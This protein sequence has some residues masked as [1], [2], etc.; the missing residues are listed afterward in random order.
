MPGF[1]SKEKIVD[2]IRSSD[3]EVGKREIA[4]AFK[5][6]GQD[7]IQLKKVLRE[8]ADDGLI[9]KGRG[10]S[11]KDPTRLPPVTVIDIV[12][13]DT[14]GELLGRPAQWES[15]KRAPQIILAPGEGAGR[16]GGPAIG[17]GARV[18]A[19]LKK[20]PDE[21]YE[22]RVIKTLGQ[23]AHKVLGVVRKG[24]NPNEFR[25]KPVDRKTRYDILVDR[26]D[27]KNAAPG[28]LVTVEVK[29]GRKHAAKRGRVLEVLGDV[30]D[31]RSVSLI[32]IHTHGIPMGFSDDEETQ[33]KKAKPPALGRR[34]DLRHLPLITIDPD[35]ARDFDDAVCAEPDPSDD[36]VGGWI[37]HVA[38]ADVA[39]FV[40][41]GT[42]LDVGARKRGNSCYFPDRV[43][44]MLPE[45]LSNELCS[46]RP[47][48]DKPCMAIRM[49][50][51]QSGKK[52][53]HKFLR[54]LMT[55]KARLT[56][57]QAQSAVDGSPDETSAPLL[58]GTLNPLW[59]AYDALAQARDR[60]KP[61]DFDLP[62][63]KIV[64]S[65]EGNVEKIGFRERLD[66]HRL[67]EEFMIQA[68]VCAAETLEQKKAPFIYRV[69]DAPSD[70]KLNA[71]KDFLASL[72][73]KMPANQVLK[74]Q[75]FNG[76]LERAKGTPHE[77]MINE[78]VLRSQSQA[79]YD[80]ENLGHFGL[81]LR[82]YSHFTS[83]IR[84]YADLVVH[85]AL[86]RYCDLGGDGL[87]Q[88]EIDT[89]SQT[90][91]LISTFERRAMAAERDS[92]DRYVASFLAD[93]VGAIFKGRIAGVTRFGLFIKLD[94]TGADG[95]V[96]MKSL[97]DDF[98]H[99]DESAH[100][101]IG[102]HSGGAYR[103]GQNVSVKLMEAAPLTGGLR[104]EMLTAADYSSRKT[105]KKRVRSL[106]SN[107]K[108]R[109]GRR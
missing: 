56:Y 27:L 29:G 96:P 7:R 93:R 30:S 108:F 44:P 64:L 91:E 101:L 71:L 43:V 61:L 36:N 84:R 57:T 100:A 35:D 10:K 37:V 39:H 6:K 94:E 8:L 98:Y 67:I 47:L 52:L 92:A 34:T 75:H 24:P 74:P 15:E 62:E 4:R 23:S 97:D 50:F 53:G 58:D 48:E 80:T 1:P 105:S 95:I 69:H 20:M 60:R 87:T 14:D 77:H 54:G 104:F 18:L 5:L 12:D 106:S 107:K 89:M 31:Q 3:S 42:P 82:R 63:H 49:V 16:R 41:T 9:E 11:L 38:I 73:I 25:V 99:H 40:R 78:V 55:S 76:I 33:A 72:D 70:E 68:N 86:I 26:R 81:N 103:L 66:A 109:R 51:D 32:A 13:Q 59:A 46:L 79:V 102:E 85:R 19:R 65:D 21:S 17:I 88:D 28:E 90:A 83:P 2:F 22:A 45:R